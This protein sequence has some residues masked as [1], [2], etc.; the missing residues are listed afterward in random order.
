MDNRGKWN[1][2]GT[3][4]TFKSWNIFVVDSHHGSSVD[5]DVPA[6]LWNESGQ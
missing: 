1:T 6:S 2:K 3:L 5:H 4:S